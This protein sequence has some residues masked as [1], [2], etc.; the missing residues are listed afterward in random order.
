MFFTNAINRIFDAAVASTATV[1]QIVTGSQ[2]GTQFKTVPVTTHDQFLQL[3]YSDTAGLDI[4]RRNTFSVLDISGTAPVVIPQL[5]GTVAFTAM[6]PSMASEVE[7]VVA[8]FAAGVSGQS[9]AG[10]ELKLNYELWGG[11]A[12]SG[13]VRIRIPAGMQIF[14]NGVSYSS[15]VVLNPFSTLTLLCVQDSQTDQNT[16]FVVCDSFGA[17]VG[18]A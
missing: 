9:K 18:L 7:A 12:T 13:T 5:F 11:G 17:P 15:A 8:P 14:H 10:Y 3:T 1:P 2:D 16:R 6:A 4:S